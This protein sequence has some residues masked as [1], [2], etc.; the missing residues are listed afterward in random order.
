M[1]VSSREGRGEPTPTGELRLKRIGLGLIAIDLVVRHPSSGGAVAPTLAAT[2][3]EDNYYHLRR[4]A[5]DAGELQKEVRWR[6]RV[7]RQS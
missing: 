5:A 7:K 2:H 4:S 3:V 6:S 1:P